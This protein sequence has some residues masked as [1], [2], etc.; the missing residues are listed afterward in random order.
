MSMESRKVQLAGQSTYT[1]SLPK[2]WAGVKPEPG[3]PA[4]F[5][6]IAE[7]WSA[8]TIRQADAR[9]EFSARYGAQVAT[10]PWRP[11]PPTDLDGLAGIVADSEGIPWS[12]LLP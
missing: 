11:N 1:I 2:E 7:Q 12:N 10:I 3:I 6:K 8:E 4:G 5:G 9:D